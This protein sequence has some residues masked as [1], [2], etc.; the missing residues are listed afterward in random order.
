MYLAGLV[1]NELRS[2]QRHFFIKLFLSS[3]EQE[4]IGNQNAATIPCS[5]LQNIDVNSLTSEELFN[6]KKYISI[7]LDLDSLDPRKKFLVMDYVYLG[8]SL[9]NFCLLLKKLFP[10]REIEGFG[11]S[12]SDELELEN[13]K[14]NDIPFTIE[15]FPSKFI[16]FFGAGTHK[17]WAPFAG[18]KRND[19]VRKEFDEIRDGDTGLFFN[20]DFLELRDYVRGRITSF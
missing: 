13:L 11:L 19:D 16:N 18:T 3:T 7:F 12:L 2:H 4:S 15:T 10:E 1:F 5:G 20:S 8:N 9:T 6:I 14:A 17:V